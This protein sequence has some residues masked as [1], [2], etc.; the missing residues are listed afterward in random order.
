VPFA[1]LLPRSGGSDALASAGPACRSPASPTGRF[2]RLIERRC[3]LVVDRCAIEERPV[4]LPGF[5]PVVVRPCERRTG[6]PAL[7]FFLLQGCGHAALH[8]TL[9]SRAF[10]RL[11]APR[12]IVCPWAST[13]T[14]AGPYPLMGFRRPSY[15]DVPDKLSGSHPLA[16]SCSASSGVAGPSASFEANASPI[17]RTEAPVVRLP[18]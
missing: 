17:H 9:C 7:G 4:R 11:F 8:K 2:R 15:A 3:V 13:P 16:R 6:D 5:I 14:V 1:G 12:E 18:V 10:P